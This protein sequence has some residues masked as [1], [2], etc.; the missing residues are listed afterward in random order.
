MAS[1]SPFLSFTLSFTILI[2]FLSGAVTA[3]PDREL[4][5]MIAVLRTRGYN[6]FGNAISTSDLYYEIL[7]GSSF[8]LFAPTDYSL[9]AL[10]MTAGLSDYIITLRHHVVPRRLSIRDLRTLPPAG[11]TLRTLVPHRDI[12]VQRNP[13]S[14]IVTVDGIDVVMPGLFYG[15]DIA[16]HGLGGILSLRYQSSPPLGADHHHSTH[17]PP[18]LYDDHGSQSPV[19]E[20]HH[21]PRPPAHFSSHHGSAV[22]GHHH[23]SPLPANVSDHYISEPPSAER[24]ENRTIVSPSPEP[25]SF[26]RLSPTKS[27]EKAGSPL[28]LLPDNGLSPESSTDPDSSPS[29]ER[30]ELS[31]ANVDNLAAPDEVWTLMQPD[32]SSTTEIPLPIDSEIVDCREEESETL[33]G[34]I[35]AQPGNPTCPGIINTRRK[36]FT[37]F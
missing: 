36:S 9:F 20:N 30:P 25:A 12:H 3:V 15:Q 35:I 16:V 4:E 5:S 19:V 8:T 18:N 37:H 23:A 21:D 24:T 32:F 31:V 29:T 13:M 27:Q 22:I 14:E 1:N 17:P 7:S 10:D 28:V 26:D 34:H 2:L 33:L 11:S 6:L